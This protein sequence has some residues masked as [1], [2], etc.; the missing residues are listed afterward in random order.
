MSDARK[1]IETETPKPEQAPLDIPNREPIDQTAAMVTSKTPSHSRHHFRPEPHQL[2]FEPWIKRFLVHPPERPSW[3]VPDRTGQRVGRLKVL[4]YSH[5]EKHAGKWKHYW[6]VQCDCGNI[7][8]RGGRALG[9]EIAQTE[10]MCRECSFTERKN[11]TVAWHA[12][13]QKEEQ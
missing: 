1:I 2:R 9:R 12:A 8:M 7:E 10:G 13:H 11:R 5:S 3:A 6:V 4:G